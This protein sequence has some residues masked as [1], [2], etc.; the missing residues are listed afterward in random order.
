[1]DN[2]TN[3]W[4]ERNLRCKPDKAVVRL[5]NDDGTFLGVVNTPTVLWPLNAPYEVLHANNCQLIEDTAVTEIIDAIPYCIGHC[6]LNAENVTKALQAAGHN[7]TQYVG[8]MFVGEQYPIHHSWTVLDGKHVIDLADEFAVLHANHKQ[9][10]ENAGMDKA[11]E[12]MV[13]F[14]KWIR[15]FPNSKRIM[16]FG[17]PAG[18]LLYIGCPCSRKEGIDIYNKLTQAYPN[19]PCNE[20]LVAGK[21]RTKMQLML[22]EAGLM[23]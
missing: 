16:P 3:A 4:Y 8:W 23:D 18:N 17:V 21:N 12:L 10:G 7:A 5:Y 11:R 6:Y 9:F 14:H 20:R 22:Q 13:E 2:A 19:H 1:M 15:Q